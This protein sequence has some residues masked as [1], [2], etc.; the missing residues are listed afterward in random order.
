MIVVLPPADISSLSFSR[1]SL[2]E[3]ARL[4]MY[5]D[6]FYHFD[7]MSQNTVGLQVSKY[8]SSTRLAQCHRCCQL[9][10]PNYRK[11]VCNTTVSKCVGEARNLTM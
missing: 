5:L 2:D 3:S 11:M 7:T 1:S 4:H 9:A 6:S 8:A 10:G